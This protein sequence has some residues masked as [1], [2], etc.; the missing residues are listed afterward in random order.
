NL[1]EPLEHVDRPG[2]RAAPVVGGGR[3][4]RPDL[5]TAVVVTSERDGGYERERKEQR[6]GETHDPPHRGPPHAFVCRRSRQSYAWRRERRARG[7]ASLAPLLPHLVSPAEGG[8][9]EESKDDKLEG[10]LDQAKGKGKEEAGKLGG[11]RS[12]EVGGKV[13][14]AK[15]KVKEDMGELKEE[16]NDD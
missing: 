11:D 7:F 1:E 16:L 3:I 6:A 14:Q 12:T 13:D 10:K 8:S 4:E 9:K 15:G 2:L 5:L